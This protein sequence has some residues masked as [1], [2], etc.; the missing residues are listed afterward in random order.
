MYE[1]PISAKTQEN[2]PHCHVPL[3]CMGPETVS[4]Y[5]IWERTYV[6]YCADAAYLRTVEI[7]YYG[8]VLSM[9]KSASVM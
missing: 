2:P 7:L 5:K 4:Y 8:A 1:E 6:T 3:M 9:Q